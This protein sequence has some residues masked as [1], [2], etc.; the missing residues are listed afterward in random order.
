LQINPTGFNLFTGK[1]L[2][3]ETGLVYFGARWYDPEIGR[4]ITLD[5]A[6]DGENWY[7]YCKSNPLRY[8]DPDGRAIPIVI[9][10]YLT[11]LAASP[12]LQLDTQQLA[13]DLSKGDY[14]TA[15]ADLL[16]IAVPGLPAS[17]TGGT[18]RFVSQWLSKHSKGFLKVISDPKILN[19]VLKVVKKPLQVHHWINQATL[20]GAKPVRLIQMAK[21]M[22]IDI[23]VEGWNKSLIPHL[24]KHTNEYF[25]FVRKLLTET[26]E[27]YLQ[28]GHNWKPNE[29]KD[30]LQSVVGEIIE[31]V[32]SGKVK[33]YRK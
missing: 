1:M 21:K 10:L 30:A 27:A 11:S 19:A 2:T 26:Y 4:W 23:V 16:A 32:S 18:T 22:G 13:F 5:P 3:E 9:Y 17:A 33:M 31:S 20:N 15:A 28:S 12:D 6:E 25:D 7:Q 8:H 24:G 29:M 14:L